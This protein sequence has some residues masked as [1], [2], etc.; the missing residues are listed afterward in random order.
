MA[1]VCRTMIGQYGLVRNERATAIVHPPKPKLN[2]LWAAGYSFSK[3]HAEVIVRNDPTMLGIFDGEEFSRG[4]R[5][6]T[7]GYDFYTPNNNLLFHDYQHLLWRGRSKRV[8]T[9]DKYNVPTKEPV[10]D[11]TAVSVPRMAALL[12][13]PNYDK[14]IDLRPHVMGTARTYDQYQH[15]SGVFPSQNIVSHGSKCGQLTWV[16]YD[17]AALAEFQAG[18]MREH[19]AAMKKTRA[20][21]VQAAAA[22]V[23]TAAVATSAPQAPARTY[24]AALPFST[25]ASV[26]ELNLPAL[27]VLALLLLC[28]V[29]MC[30]PTLRKAVFGK[31][32]WKGNVSSTVRA[33][34]KD[35]SKADAKRKH[36]EEPD[37]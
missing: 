2:T 35:S 26:P 27:V 30:V 37:V 15:F 5:M 32:C 29:V 23:Q 16:P 17:A 21:T 33:L 19:Y 6:W 36:A 18:K 7:H 11:V 24:T 12:Q 13:L 25:E 31:A 14:N 1:H 9:S 8:W 3:C 20:V 4:A 28:V 22:T 10:K 34:L